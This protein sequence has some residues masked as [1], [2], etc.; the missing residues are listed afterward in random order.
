MKHYE[1]DKERLQKIKALLVSGC[2][3]T[4]SFKCVVSVSL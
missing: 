4:L 2:V 1:A 3:F